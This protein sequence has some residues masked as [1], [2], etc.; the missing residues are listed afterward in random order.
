MAIKR[1]I[2]TAKKKAQLRHCKNN[3]FA[4]PMGPFSGCLIKRPYIIT[5]IR[6]AAGTAQIFSVGLYTAVISFTN[7]E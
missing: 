5:G 7:S 6:K 3:P 1:K 4:K 2:N